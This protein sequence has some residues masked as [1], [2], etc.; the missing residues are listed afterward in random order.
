LNNTGISNEAYVPRPSP[1]F[2]KPQ[3][4][5]NSVFLLI[6]LKRSLTQ[7]CIALNPLITDDAVPAFLLLHKLT[8]LSILD[9]AINMPGLRRLAR[10]IHDEDRVIDIEIPTVCELYVDSKPLHSFSHELLRLTPV[11]LF[12]F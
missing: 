6:A 2:P 7:L 8:F 10:T 12:E 3:F 1:S 4:H 11:I 9:T 5:P